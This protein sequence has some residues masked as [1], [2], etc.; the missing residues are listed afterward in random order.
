[1]TEVIISCSLDQPSQPRNLTVKERVKNTSSYFDVSWDVPKNDG[2]VDAYVVRWREEDGI[3]WSQEQTNATKI[4]I[5]N[6]TPATKYE[7]E[8]YAINFVWNGNSTETT[9]VTGIL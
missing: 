2:K 1:M 5:M 3:K 8:V 6:L 7:I 4:T 9:A